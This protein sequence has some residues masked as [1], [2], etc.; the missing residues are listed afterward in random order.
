MTRTEPRNPCT[1][2]H[3]LLQP[4][5]TTKSGIASGMTSSTAQTRRPGRFVR[6]TSQAAP[7]PM[8]A[9]RKVTATVSRT[10]FHSSMPVSGRKIWPATVLRPAPCD[11]TMRNTSGT[12]S[13]AAMAA[14][15]AIRPGRRRPRRAGTAATASVAGPACAVWLIAPVLIG[16][17]RSQQS[18]LAQQRDCPTAVAELADGDRVRP[19]LAERR[20]GR[21]SGHAGCDRVLE[22]QRV[23]I[24]LAGSPDDFL[25]LLADQERQELLRFGLMLTRAHDPGAGHVHH[26]TGIAGR[27]KR[28]PGVN[29]C[30]SDLGSQA[31][32][33]VLVD[34]PEGRLT[35]VHL[36]HHGLIVAV[37]MVRGIRV[38]GFQPGERRGLAVRPQVRGH[39]RLEVRLTR[40]ERQLAAVLLVGQLLDLGR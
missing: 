9:H 36:V 37:D 2:V 33:V 4:K 25:A 14:L 3:M 15:T 12:A 40:R 17:P 30:R 19:Q 21:L 31:E 32:P 6:S 27:E 38:D 29:V 35:P 7:V 10:V 23:A 26:V 8:T 11:S 16:V 24:A 5:L 34:D 18:G 22:A 13:S 20:L 39:D 28:Q 1:Q